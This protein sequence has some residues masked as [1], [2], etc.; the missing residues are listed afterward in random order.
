MSRL[1][2]IEEWELLWGEVEDSNHETPSDIVSNFAEIV[3]EQTLNIVANLIESKRIAPG[4]KQSFFSD[5][6]LADLRQGKLH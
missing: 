6:D 5:E 1:E 4:A 3:R 2:R